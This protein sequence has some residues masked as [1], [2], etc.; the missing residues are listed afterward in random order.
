MLRRAATGTARLPAAR[1][2]ARKAEIS[3]HDRKLFLAVRKA[4]LTLPDVEATTRYDGGP[5]LKMRGCFLAGLAT[6]PSAESGTL[7]VR[8][9]FEDRGWLLDEAPE[10]YYLTDHYRPYPVVLARLSRLTSD[11][12]RD[13]LA[14]SWRLTAAKPGARRAATRRKS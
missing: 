4:G 7:V 10:T 14:S 8:S 12:L 3:A 11:A 2:R 1:S 9:T 6:H 13:L 5:V